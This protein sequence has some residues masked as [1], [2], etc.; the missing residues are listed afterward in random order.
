MRKTIRILLMLCAVTALLAAGAQAAGTTVVHAGDADTLMSYLKD[1]AHDLEITLDGNK[2]YVVYSTYI[3]QQGEEMKQGFT[4]ENLSNVAIRGQEGTRILTP[5]ECGGYAVLTFV[6]C[7]NVTLDTLSVG[8]QDSWCDA[9]VLALAG[10]TGVEI[11]NC[12][13]WGCGYYGIS[14]SRSSFHAKD[15]VIRDCKGFIT[16]IE[17]STAVFDGC[18]FRGNGGGNTGGSAAALQGAPWN[19]VTFNHCAFT[20]NRCP[21]KIESGQEDRYTFNDCTETNNDW[22]Q[23]E[24][25][26]SVGN[27]VQMTLVRSTGRA[28]FSGTGQMMGGDISDEIKADI[29]S[30]VVETGITSTGYLFSNCVNLE[31]VSL[32]DTLTELGSFSRAEKLKEIRIP[33]SVTS[34]SSSAFSGCTGLQEII[35]PSRVTYIGSGAFFGCTGLESVNI[36]DQI[37]RISSNT[38]SYC[39]SLKSVRIPASVT[40]IESSVFSGCTGLESVNIPDGITR[41]S[42]S[43]F[44]GCSSLESVRIPDGVTAI[45]RNAFA[46]CSSLKAVSIPNGVTEISETL[47]MD[48]RSLSELVIPDSVRAIG[49]SA[50]SGCSGLKSVNIPDGVTVIDQYVFKDCSLLQEMII[51]NGVTTISYG[52]FQG[53]SGLKKLVVPGSV[54]DIAYGVFSDCTGLE[55]LTMPATLDYYGKSA[56]NF[57]DNMRRVTLTGPGKMLELNGNMPWRETKVP[58]VVEIEDGVTNIGAYAFSMCKGLIRVEI[59]DSVA[60][61]DKHAFSQC[62]NLTEITIPAGVTAI[63][64]GALSGCTNLKDIYYGGTEEQW[65]QAIASSALTDTPNVTVHFGTSGSAYTAS[66]INEALKKDSLSDIKEDLCGINQASLSRALLEGETLAKIAAIEG[67]AA[68]EVSVPSG[69]GFAAED[70][71][72]TGAKVNF[73]NEADVGLKLSAPVNSGI[74]VPAADKTLRFSAELVSGDGTL[75]AGSLAVPVAVTILLSDRN[76]PEKCIRVWHHHDETT[77]EVMYTSVTKDEQG[78]RLTFI[79]DGFSDIVVTYDLPVFAVTRLSGIPTAVK[80]RDDG[81]TLAGCEAI[82]AARYEN[83][84]MTDLF[85]GELSDS[86]ITFTAPLK[87]GDV[88]FFLDGSSVPVQAKTPLDV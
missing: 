72:I 14:A 2:D 82:Y 10:S 65:N 34:I 58:C 49:S 68:V 74:E 62:T 54:T 26:L 50:F 64:D 60:S 13:L 85:A 29:V 66:A 1:G 57:S 33:D 44:S 21:D 32:P 48:C 84:K 25:T 28:V 40:E 71:V 52:A 3:N 4:V 6:N 80:V 9:P 78:T 70:T 31:K 15:T 51:P 77:N 88:L 20:D 47:F 86:R 35:I 73:P 81:E 46:G 37:T 79:L 45:G 16:R 12:D 22:S 7:Q 53:C 56:F 5:S 41:I 75:E 69:L 67:E 42:D 76:I 83:G 36:P 27:D 19:D 59:P 23:S 63:G 11:L 24:L 8:H 39:T 18:T 55:E 30:A 61:I 87:A 43:I 17:A 38:F